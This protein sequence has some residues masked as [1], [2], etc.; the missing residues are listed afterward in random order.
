[1]ELIKKVKSNYV[2]I[3]EILPGELFLDCTESICIKT[4]SLQ[5]NMFPCVKIETGTFFWLSES[6]K[7]RRVKQLNTLEVEEV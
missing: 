6:N 7:V 5:S 2:C 4:N 3:S 1:M